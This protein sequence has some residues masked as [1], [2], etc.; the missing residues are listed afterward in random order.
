MNQGVV[1]KSNAGQKYTTDAVSVALLKKIAAKAEVK[2][3]WFVNN[4]D[5]RGGSTLGN[6]SSHSIYQY[7]GC[8]IGTVGNALML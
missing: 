3:Q 7:S 1:V 5:V 6:I 8:G 2:L 4:S